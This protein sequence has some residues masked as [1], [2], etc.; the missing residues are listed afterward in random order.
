MTLLQEWM[1][2]A[3]LTD[4]KLASLMEGAVTRSQINR[5]RRGESRPSLETAR[6]LEQV[7]RI[8]AHKF[9]MGDAA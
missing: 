6:A 7:T 9:V 5:I 4:A 8:P 1:E 2:R 3:D